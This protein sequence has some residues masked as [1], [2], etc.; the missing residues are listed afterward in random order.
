MRPE[1]DECS[2][3][4][5]GSTTTVDGFQVDGMVLTPGKLQKQEIILQ[6]QD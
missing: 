1:S 6:G 5:H 4:E 2:G 3:E